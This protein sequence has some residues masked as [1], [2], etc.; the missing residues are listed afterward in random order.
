MVITLLFMVVVFL[1]LILPH[2]LGHF[3]VAKASGMK[4][5]RFSLGFG[6]KLWGI[7]R[8]ETEYIISALPLGGYV[9]IAGMQPGEQWIEGGFYSKSLSKRLAV[10]LSGS[11]MNFLVSIILFS[12]I[13]MVGFNTVDLKTPVVGEI[14]PGSPAQEAGIKPGDRILAVNEHKI[15][16][17][18]QMASLIQSYRE[19]KLKLLIL[20]GEDKLMVEVEPKYYP[21]YK[22]KL[23]GIS[24]STKF[25]RYNPLASLVLGA[26]RVA[27]FIGFIFQ[28]LMGMITG[29]VPAQFAGPVGIMEY[30]GEATRLGIIPFISLAALLGVNLGLFNLFPIPALDGGRLLFLILEVIRRK[31]VEVELQEF[32]HYIGFLILII[33]MLLITYQDIL[34]L[35]R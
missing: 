3:L 28:A 27:F 17:W 13:F 10:L 5:E 23:I 6:P 32:A 21:E 24:P 30:V 29:K 7:K 18:Q 15:K 25:V 20:R 19:G 31:P 9:K 4:V 11:A 12:L 1:L 22:K 26:G 2:E 35:I 16:E 8:K 33:L 14:I 34:R